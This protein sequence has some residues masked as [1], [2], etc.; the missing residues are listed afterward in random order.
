MIGVGDLYW[1][2]RFVI[3]NWGIGLDIRI[4]IGIGIGDFNWGLG[5]EIGHCH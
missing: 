1:G 5:I 4:R 2:S 3:G